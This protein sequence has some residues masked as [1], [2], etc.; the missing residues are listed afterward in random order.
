M[1]VL[2]LLFCVITKYYSFLD[3]TLILKISRMTVYI[4][5]VSLDINI[6]HFYAEKTVTFSELSM[7]IE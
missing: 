7:G 2:G 3:H 4:T 1:I 5:I 6:S